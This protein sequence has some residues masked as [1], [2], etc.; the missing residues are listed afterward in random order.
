MH[1]PASIHTDDVNMGWEERANGREGLSSHVTHRHN[2]NTA[3]RDSVSTSFTQKPVFGFLNNCIP[4]V[5]DCSLLSPPI[6]QEIQAHATAL[7]RIP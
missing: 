2:V 5:N 7:T 6:K 1:F 4:D 3:A